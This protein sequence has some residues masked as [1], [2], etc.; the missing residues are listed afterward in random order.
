MQS[1][2]DLCS[3]DTH[4]QLIKKTYNLEHGKLNYKSS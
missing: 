2:Q 3:N 4:E 1:L